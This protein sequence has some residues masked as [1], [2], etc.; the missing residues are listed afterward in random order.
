VNRAVTSTISQADQSS[1]RVAAIRSATAASWVRSGGPRHSHLRRAAALD[2]LLR[3]A[4]YA[5]L[6]FT[7]VLWPDFD[8]A[9]FEAALADYARRDRRFGLAAGAAP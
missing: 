9:A 3:E 7:P 6:Y 4:A 8:R 2:F 1:G 5:E